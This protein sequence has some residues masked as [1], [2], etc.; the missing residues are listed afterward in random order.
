LRAGDR[1]RAEADVRRLGNNLGTNRRYRL[2]YLR[3]QA[4]L[5]RDASANDAAIAHLGEALDLGAQMD[6]PGEE[7]QISAELAASYAAVEDTA[8]A[9]N[10]RQRA[11]QVVATLTARIADPTLSKHFAR[12]AMSR[13]PALG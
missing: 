7:W 10:A 2:L 8:H 9:A 13:R 6:L 4:L 5:D 11:V 1:A 3:M 12:T